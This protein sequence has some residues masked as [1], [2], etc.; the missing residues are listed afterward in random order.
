M[1]NISWFI[2]IVAG[3][4]SLVWVWLAVEMHRHKEPIP[5]RTR[6]DVL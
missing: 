4:N 5:P 6:E 2:L 3:I 1:N